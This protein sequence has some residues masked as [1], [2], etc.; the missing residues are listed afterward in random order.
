MYK[1]ERNAEVS[2]A[3]EKES[4]HRDNRCGLLY[5]WHGSRCAG[6]DDRAYGTGLNRLVLITGYV[7]LRIGAGLIRFR[8]EQVR[9]ICRSLRRTVL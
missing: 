4:H 6:G 1:H 7:S 2:D 3:M 8:A 9:G 5:H